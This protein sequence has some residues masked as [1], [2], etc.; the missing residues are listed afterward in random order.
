MSY[1]DTTSVDPVSGNITFYWVSRDSDPETGELMSTCDLW[2]IRPIREAKGSKGYWWHT[3]D[4]SP[5]GVTLVGREG[6]FSLDAV[7]L[8]C[9]TVPETDRELLVV[10]RR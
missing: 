6:C 1:P 4:V 10:G 8:W 2:S 7:R 3:L 5:D 9:G